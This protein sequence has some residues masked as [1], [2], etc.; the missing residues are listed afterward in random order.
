MPYI[1]DADG[2]IHSGGAPHTVAACDALLSTNDAQIRALLDVRGIIEARR[3][4]LRG[5]LFLRWV[6]WLKGW[7]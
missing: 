4:A 7:M 2:T 1:I 5:P 3:R 6:R